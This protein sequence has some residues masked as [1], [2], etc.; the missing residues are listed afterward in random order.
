MTDEE[1]KKN[2]ILGGRFYGEKLD[3]LQTSEENHWQE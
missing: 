1:V 2:I 3:E